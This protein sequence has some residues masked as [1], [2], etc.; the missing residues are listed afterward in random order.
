MSAFRRSAAERYDR[1]WRLAALS[2]TAEE[3]LDRGDR[4][5]RHATD[6]EG[7]DLS[8]GNEQIELGSADTGHA[9]G[10]L[11]ADRDRRG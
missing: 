3:G 1:D 8:I 9:T 10:I 7:L 2:P 4:Y 5:E 11:D 6:L